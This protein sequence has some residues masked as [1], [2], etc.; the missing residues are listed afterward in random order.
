[1]YAGHVFWNRVPRH[2][3]RILLFSVHEL[4]DTYYYDKYGRI[5]RTGLFQSILPGYTFWNRALGQVR[6]PTT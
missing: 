6:R 4:L 1:M 3:K 2:V 5:F